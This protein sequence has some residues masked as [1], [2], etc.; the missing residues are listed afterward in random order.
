MAETRI[1]YILNRFDLDAGNHLAYNARFVAALQTRIPVF[2]IVESGFDR[3]PPG[4]ERS[5]AYGQHFRFP[6]LR[7]AELLVVLLCLRLRGWRSIYVHYSLWGGLAAGLLGT[8]L[9]G[10]AYYWSCGLVHDYRRSGHS[11]VTRW[12]S[13]LKNVLALQVI[14]GLGVRLVTGA[15]TMVDYY[16]DRYR[17]LRAVH[18]LPNWV[19]VPPASGVRDRQDSRRALGLPR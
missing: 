4:V 3:P 8:V 7:F 18:V 9:G 2:L 1:V 19:E 12:A 10:R 11:R 5:R 14:F 16:R 15:R 17:R 6:P 13:W